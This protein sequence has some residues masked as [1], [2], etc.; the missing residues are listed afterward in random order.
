MPPQINSDILFPCEIVDIYTNI[1][2]KAP[3]SIKNEL[4]MMEYDQL[5]NSIVKYIGLTTDYADFE[6]YLSSARVDDTVDVLVMA[7]PEPRLD[8]YHSSDYDVIQKS[9]LDYSNEVVNALGFFPVNF[10][11]GIL[12]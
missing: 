12:Q 1:Q 11:M 9:V 10:E 5:Y 7:L 3:N 4:V 8:F 2:G 6:A